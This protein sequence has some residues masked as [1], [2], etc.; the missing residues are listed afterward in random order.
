MFS[1]NV[2]IPGVRGTQAA[3]NFDDPAASFSKADCEEFYRGFSNITCAGTG[4]AGE[5]ANQ[6]LRSIFST[7]GGFRV[8]ASLP[9]KPGIDVQALEEALG[10]T[11]E[12]ALHSGERIEAAT[13]AAALR[14]S[15][16]SREAPARAQ[17]VFADARLDASP[18]DG[19]TCAGS[20]PFFL[21]DL[22]AGADCGD[23]VELPAGGSVRVH[24]PVA[25]AGI[26]CPPGSPLVVTA[27][28]WDLPPGV[29]VTPS[30]ARRMAR[31]EAASFPGTIF[32]STAAAP[33]R[34]VVFRGLELVG[35]E[36]P[37]AGPLLKF[38]GVVDIRIDQ[39]YLRGSG[40]AA[41]GPAAILSGDRLIVT[42][43]F[44]D[45]FWAQVSGPAVAT[46]VADGPGS[47]EF[48]NNYIEAA[49]T[50]LSARGGAA[51]EFR[52]NTVHRPFSHSRC[53][54][55][56]DAVY[57]SAGNLI[58]IDDAAG[59][60]EYNLLE[61]SSG[62]P[63]SPAAVGLSHPSAVVFRVNTFRNVHSAFRI[64]SPEGL[65]TMAA[66]SA[67]SPQVVV[68][69]NVLEQ[70][71]PSSIASLCALPGAP[72]LLAQNTRGSLPP[73]FLSLAR[74]TTAY[75]VAVALDLASRAAGRAIVDGGHT[76]ARI[77][78]LHTTAHGSEV[79]FEYAVSAAGAG[80]P[81][82]LELWPPARPLE[83]VSAF[84]NLSGSA[85]A[86]AVL[87]PSPERHE[88]RLMCGG[89]LQRGMI[90]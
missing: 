27:T 81:C 71:A 29:R 9:D 76:T 18:C 23:R 87:V 83:S 32:T 28:G 20:D 59:V 13:G 64:D 42:N 48:T 37:Q 85:R 36:M 58:E 73:G 21:R 19:A 86:A 16:P 4:Q 77:L 60:F 89:D 53:R 40:A 43:S 79:L 88:F 70:S 1:D 67:G 46:V 38:A 5:T 80:V 65:S 50:A 44:F 15:A 56:W 49:T 7:P 35:S 31:I 68:E 14:E 47:I 51:I 8:N 22:L 75:P 61:D 90:P 10:M 25:L 41:S 72:V 74:N 6:R 78:N 12:D 34:G 30:Q 3:K 45:G 55:E 24:E 84:D 17:T 2:V 63:Q 69:D 33:V 54:S 11:I 26:D 52:Y 57:R 82:T 62:G 39:C 66:M